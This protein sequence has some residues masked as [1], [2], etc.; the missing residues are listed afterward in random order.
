MQE[1]PLTWHSWKKFCMEEWVNISPSRC[2][3]LVD[4]YGKLYMKLF[5]PKREILVTEA[6]GALTFSQDENNTSV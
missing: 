3:R 4:N 6:K 5:L 1:T 2:Q